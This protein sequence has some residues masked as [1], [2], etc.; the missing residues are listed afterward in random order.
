VPRRAQVLHA[1]LAVPRPARGASIAAH[2]AVSLLQHACVCVSQAASTRCARRG[3]CCRRHTLLDCAPKPSSVMCTCCALSLSDK[4]TCV[5]AE[6]STS[7][8]SSAPAGA[9]WGA[10][11]RAGRMDDVSRRRRTQQH[12]PGAHPFRFRRALRRVRQRPLAAASLLHGGVAALS[13]CLQR[14]ERD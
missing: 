6:P 5:G 12:A 8:S 10:G 14:R 2:H 3:A 4:R 13:S 1:R 11:A 7:C 9:C